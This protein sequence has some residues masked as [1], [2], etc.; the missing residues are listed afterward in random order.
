M[1]INLVNHMNE[2]IASIGANWPAATAGIGLVME[3]DAEYLKRTSCQ[4]SFNNANVGALTSCQE[5]CRGDQS[6]SRL[7]PKG[8]V[9]FFTLFTQAAFTAKEILVTCQASGFPN[10][11]IKVKRANPFSRQEMAGFV[12]AIKITEKPLEAEVESRPDGVGYKVRLPAL[13]RKTVST[14]LGP[15]VRL[16]AP[17]QKLVMRIGPNEVGKP[18]IPMARSLIAIPVGAKIEH[19]EIVGIGPHTL[20]GIVLYPVQNDRWDLKDYPDSPFQ[21]DK[22]IYKKAVSHIQDYE[23][24]RIRSQGRN[25]VW[26]T[27]PLVDYDPTTGTLTTYDNIETRISFDRQ[28]TCYQDSPKKRGDSL[29]SLLDSRKGATESLL[30]NAEALR[31]YACIEGKPIPNP[32]TPGVIIDPVPVGPGRIIPNPIDPGRVIITPTPIDPGRVVVIPGVIV[33]PRLIPGR[34]AVLPEI[35]NADTQGFEA[36]TSTTLRTTVEKPQSAPVYGAPDDLEPRLL[37][38]YPDFYEPHVMRLR[39]HKESLGLT[40]RLIP[41]SEIAAA[42]GSVSDAAIKGYCDDIYASATLKPKWLLLFGDVTDIPTHYAANLKNSEDRVLDAGDAW[43]GQVA[44]QNEDEIPLVAVGRL[45]IAD[46]ADAEAAVSKILTYETRPPADLGFTQRV[47]GTSTFLDMNTDNQSDSRVYA[48]VVERQYAD[49][50]LGAGKSFDRLNAA[51][52]GSFPTTWS[53]GN[54]L[55]PGLRVTSIWQNSGPTV[56]TQLLS[57]YFV[58][59]HR[60]HALWDRWGEPDLTADDWRIVSGT[61]SNYGML[62]LLIGV[63]CLSGLFDNETVLNQENLTG[64]RPFGFASD[65]P[66]AGEPTLGES[67]IRGSAIGFIG[68]SRS[69]RTV[70]NDVIGEGF[71]KAV[72]D[73]DKPNASY[74]LG[75]ILGSGKAFLASVASNRALKEQILIYNLLGD[76]SV[77]LHTMPS[78]AVEPTVRKVNLGTTTEV[79]VGLVF[80]NPRCASCAMDDDAK[81]AEIAARA[82]RVVIQGAKGQV[83]S[84]GLFNEQGLAVMVVPTDSLNGAR[85][86]MS[87]RDLTARATAL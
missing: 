79:H 57:G 21:M 2:R 32:N 35:P 76:P 10:H 6:C 7:C 73:T 36:L 4:A 78:L 63:N 43:Y 41:L 29:D 84:R 77:E 46:E 71:L 12:T 82:P 42:K 66:S 44:K 59:F 50:I 56:A 54:P 58:G 55:D 24:D 72:V 48:E 1:G 85:L 9:G 45:P 39:M 64:G 11:A 80:S 22:K 47:L 31:N 17:A 19:I 60:G 16:S 67:M 61:T 23:A 14:P 62:P 3:A 28:S 51:S 34:G 53:D 75:D 81:A 87:G 13:E 70:F 83:L 33:G 49:S 37:V 52:L 8:D 27:Y 15:M 74:R 25:L 20:S 5:S 26:L 18:E 38:I 65:L 69:S 86:M 40:T 68:A 30:I